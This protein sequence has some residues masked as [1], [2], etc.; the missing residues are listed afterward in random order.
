MKAKHCQQMD[1]LQRIGLV[2]IMV[3]NNKELPY[4]VKSH[5]VWIGYWPDSIMAKSILFFRLLCAHHWNTD[6]D[7]MSSHGLLPYVSIF[8][9]IRSNVNGLIALGNPTSVPARHTLRRK[10]SQSHIEKNKTREREKKPCTRALIANTHTHTYTH[11]HQMPIWAQWSIFISWNIY[12]AIHE[13]W[14]KCIRVL[15]FSFQQVICCD[16]FGFSY[17]KIAFKIMRLLSFCDIHWVS[18][19]RVCMCLFA[20]CFVFFSGTRKTLWNS[21]RS[22]KPSTATK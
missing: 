8:G 15:S 9:K 19:A 11:T 22:S 14:W 7:R 17:L 18:C 5:S 20:S 21:L 10:F 1:S 3:Y 2:L 6:R 16:C 4:S 12:G 13:T